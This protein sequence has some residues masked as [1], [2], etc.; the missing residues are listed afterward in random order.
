MNE[1]RLFDFREAK[2]CVCCH[3]EWKADGP[4]SARRIFSSLFGGI[5]WMSG[6]AG[7]H[8]WADRRSALYFWQFVNE[9]PL[10]LIGGWEVVM[11]Q[12]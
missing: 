12:F 9:I 2:A 4:P 7:K 1:R 11:A 3:R 5:L 8:F 6:A 10:E